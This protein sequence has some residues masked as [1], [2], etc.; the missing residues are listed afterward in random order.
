MW[1]R[2]EARS[3]WVLLKF[4]E[5]EL[6]FSSGRERDIQAAND[7]YKVAVRHWSAAGR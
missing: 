1:M 7:F 4:T 5:P 2:R 6:T 3:R